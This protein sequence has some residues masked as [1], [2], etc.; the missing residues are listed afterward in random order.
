MKFLRLQST[1]CQYYDVTNSVVK[2]ITLLVNYVN[3]L[4]FLSDELIFQTQ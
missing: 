2:K 4:T 1:L 3:M